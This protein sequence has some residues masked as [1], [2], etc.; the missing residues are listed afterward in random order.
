MKYAITNLTISAFTDKCYLQLQV[1]CLN[2]REHF[3]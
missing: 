2:K 1:C 3:S